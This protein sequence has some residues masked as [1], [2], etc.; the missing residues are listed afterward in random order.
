MDV[1]EEMLCHACKANGKVYLESVGKWEE[2]YI[3]FEEKGILDID[4]QVVGDAH[5]GKNI[6]TSFLKFL[7]YRGYGFASEMDKLKITEAIYKEC[8]EMYYARRE[9]LALFQQI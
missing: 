4:I 2:N 8:C 6:N 1:E 5:I 9:P 7:V 3:F